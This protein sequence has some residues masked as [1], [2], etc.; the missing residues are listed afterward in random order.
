MPFIGGLHLIIAIGLAIHAMKTGRPYYWLF[1]LLFVPALGS[2]A[3]VIF[4]IVPEMAKSRR[5]QKV[6]NDIGDL[7][8][9]DREWRRRSEAVALTG[10]VQAKRELAD[11]C[12]RKGMWEDA[13]KLYRECA[14]GMFADDPAIL[15]GLARAELGAGDAAGAQATLERLRDAH[16]KLQNQEAHLLYAR[17]LE[18]QDRL[19]EAEEE[20][21]SL[22]GYYAGFEART[23]Y[24][25]L[26]LRRGEIERARSQFEDVVK[27][28]GARRVTVTEADRDWLKV[29]KANL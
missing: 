25:L 29:A 21:Q 7:L 2:I 28:A 19:K 1:I 5:A 11:E 8:D 22:A 6:S 10:T 26:L 17:S 27:A 12:E 24:G 23:R 3:Y 14:Q 4:E 15:F 9:P 13:I 18:A 16:P 20:Y